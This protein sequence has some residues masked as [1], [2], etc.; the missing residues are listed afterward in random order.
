MLS[1]VARTDAI[2]PSHSCRRTLMSTDT[3]EARLRCRVADLYAP[4]PQFAAARPDEAITAAIEAP[5]LRLLEIVRTVTDGYADRPALGQRAV[6]LVHGSDGRT[7]LELLPR[8]E[9]VTY[10]GLW[11]RA[12]ALARVLANGQ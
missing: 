7:S 12:W 9:T 8:F 3:R 1:V 5:G 11:D 4:D 10:R 2:P 6:Q